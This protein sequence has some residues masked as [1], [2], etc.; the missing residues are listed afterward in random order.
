MIKS[1][2]AFHP[3]ERKSYL[4]LLRPPA[5]YV[6]DVALATTYG[7]ELPVMAAALLA[8]VKL[9]AD[10]EVDVEPD[11]GT[12]PL[13][14]LKAIL[15]LRDKV[16]VVVHRGGIQAMRKRRSRA[17]AL[18][19]SFL[20]EHKMGLGK[21]FH[22]KIWVIRYRSLDGE[23]PKYRILCL[24][25]NMTS[26]R[27]WE[28]GMVLEGRK[29]GSGEYLPELS[30]FLTDL[31][32]DLEIRPAFT[33]LAREIR[34]VSFAPPIPNASISFRYQGPGTGRSLWPDLPVRATKLLILSPFLDNRFL[35]DLA[36][37]RG[38]S[39]GLTIVSLQASLDRLDP[40]TL[41][42]L[43]EADIYCLGDGNGLVGEDSEER[44]QDLHAKMVLASTGLLSECWIG[45]ANATANG[46]QGH[47]WEAMIR[48]QG[49]RLSALDL[50]AFR[51][52]VLDNP[53]FGAQ[54]Y[55][56]T[57]PGSQEMEQAEADDRAASVLDEIAQWRLVGHLQT[58]PEKPA[59]LCVVA[60]GN[61]IRLPPGCSGHVGLFPRAPD[62]DLD[63]FL[64]DRNVTFD[65]VPPAEL[66]R[67]LEVH[68]EARVRSAVSTR[69]RM[70][71]VEISDLIVGGLTRDQWLLKELL[72]D[73]AEVF[74]YLLTILQEHDPLVA[75]IQTA[76]ASNT[77]EPMLIGEHLLAEM[78]R[79]MTLEQLLQVCTADREKARE[80]DDFV[81]ELMAISAGQQDSPLKNADVKRFIGMWQE[82]RAALEA[83]GDAR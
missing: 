73:P 21:A 5:R 34:L 78:V 22:P 49:E 33:K 17:A 6:T 32:S 69:R 63:Q 41:S 8:L 3:D 83:L 45:S 25:R 48:L 70:L 16:A 2:S 59:R 24:S 65:G 74:R 54:P 61:P 43:N 64:T 27:Q 77:R 31:M 72:S 55:I 62:R 12:G 1:V 79:R 80:I 71:L 10:T 66:S 56:W 4:D 15:R 67:L 82:I 18:L 23:S 38:S 53:H 26:S 36:R 13:A 19:D 40:R 76:R 37:T 60:E 81:R 14:Y 9:D 51:E 11:E 68:V 57:P 39:R 50:S 42:S 35:N 29:N 20:Y 44:L 46:W 58:E 28:L 47:N 7:L 52:E 30:S 75:E